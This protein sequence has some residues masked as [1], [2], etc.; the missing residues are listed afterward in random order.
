MKYLYFSILLFAF[1]TVLS[2]NISLSKDSKVS[3]LT[4]NK[5]AEL[6]SLYGHTALRIKDSKINLDIIFNYGA[7]D[8]STPNFYLKFIK[9]DLQYFVTTNVFN[10]FLDQYTQENR[11]VFEQ[12]LIL[13]D[14]QKQQL[15]NNLT[16]SL[17]TE[18]RFYTYKYIDRNCTTMVMEQVNK[19]LVRNKIPLLQKT[20]LTYREILYGYQK[21]LFF[22]N[23]GINIIFGTLVDDLGLQIFLPKDLMNSLNQNPLISKKAIILNEVRPIENTTP[24]WNSIYVFAGFMLL[25]ALFS[26][27]RVVLLTFLI[28][29]GILGLFFTF[30]GLYSF[31]KEVLW[32]YNVMLFNPL[33]LLLVFFILNKKEV[34]AYKL[35]FFCFIILLIYTIYVAF[36]IQFILVLPILV[37]TFLILSRI[38]FKKRHLIPIING[39]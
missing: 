36:N 11:A 24:F 1:N 4:C 21:D 14:L 9:G 25:I 38:A 33:F 16:A 20:Q 6:Y 13:T 2:Q 23:L 12:E 28:I 39:F 35:A 37:P 5:G 34:F 32:N 31:H 17:L 15:L 3:I 22:E 27:K 7:F 30:V 8:F 26:K 18:D 29:M 10:E 19:V